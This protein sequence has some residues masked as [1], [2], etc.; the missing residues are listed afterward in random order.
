M[1]SIRAA[2]VKL[3]DNNLLN[4]AVYTAKPNKEVIENKSKLYL[5]R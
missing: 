2:I 1:I 4:N 3:E 5:N